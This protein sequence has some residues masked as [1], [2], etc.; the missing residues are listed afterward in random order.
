[1]ARARNATDAIA[2]TRFAASDAAFEKFKPLL[3][4]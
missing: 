4:I 3:A 2:A 1:M